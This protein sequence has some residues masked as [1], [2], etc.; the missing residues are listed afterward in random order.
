VEYEYRA[1]ARELLRTL[2]LRLRPR[3]P[4]TV[5]RPP[6]PICRRCRHGYGLR[7]RGLD[8][9]ALLT[10]YSLPHSLERVP[11][12]VP[13]RVRA[14]PP[15]AQMARTSRRGRASTCSRERRPTPDYHRNHFYPVSHD[16]AGRLP[17]P[18]DLARCASLTA[19]AACGSVRCRTGPRMHIP[20][21]PSSA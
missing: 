16:P 5:H 8:A 12:S 7:T 20:P 21:G 9:R 13:Y 11:C 3:P 19:V 4:S 6:T 18:L 14:L 1:V 10:Q 17:P 2:R 15:F